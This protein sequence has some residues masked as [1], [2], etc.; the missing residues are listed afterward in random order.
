MAPGPAARLRT[1]TLPGLA[2][3]LRSRPRS[4]SCPLALAPPSPFRDALCA[5]ES[6]ALES[7]T[8]VRKRKRLGARPGDAE[9][10]AWLAGTVPLRG[11]LAASL[12]T[13][14]FHLAQRRAPRPPHLATSPSPVFGRPF[15]VP[16]IPRPSAA[17]RDPL[18]QGLIV[19]RANLRARDYQLDLASNLNKTQMVSA[20]MPLSQQGGYYCNVC[21]CILKDS[22][23]YLDHI[24]GKWHQRALGMSMRVEQ[25]T[26]EQVRG[27]LVRRLGFGRRRG[28]TRRSGASPELRAV[29]QGKA[30]VE[31]HAKVRDGAE[32]EGA[33][34]SLCQTLARWGTDH[35][36][37]TGVLRS[38]ATLTH[39]PLVPSLPRRSDEPSRLPRQNGA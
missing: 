16:S 39:P 14:L 34:R 23:S 10:R 30:T 24:N 9:A 22:L 27:D 25:S 20:A 19:E 8:D 12:D 38:P 11:A 17:E 35:P 5:Q 2:T 31:A 13:R 7:K 28:L 37:F 33:A 4:R 3:P 32:S 15:F 18:H 1:P 6:A 21:D 26:V 29:D 36:G